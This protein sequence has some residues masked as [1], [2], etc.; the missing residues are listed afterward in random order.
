MLLQSCTK[1]IFLPECN[2]SFESVHCIAR[3]DQDISAALP[4]LNAELAGIQY[5][6][7]PPA[8]MFHVLRDLAS[9]KSGK[10]NIFFIPSIQTG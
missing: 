1:D 2:P 5:F 3:L 4:Y 7:D 10:P 6:K 8:V 9:G